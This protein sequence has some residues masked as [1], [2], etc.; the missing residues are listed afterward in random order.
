MLIVCCIK[1]KIKIHTI[2]K[3]ILLT[4]T[5]L[6]KQSYNSKCCNYTMYHITNFIARNERHSDYATLSD[7]PCLIPNIYSKF[8]NCITNTAIQYDSKIELGQTNASEQTEL[9]IVLSRRRQ[10]LSLGNSKSPARS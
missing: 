9:K 2:C 10:T 5:Q 7:H 3:E 1:M 6:I 4:L 8:T